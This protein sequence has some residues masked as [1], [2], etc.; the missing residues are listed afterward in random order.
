MSWVKET[1][2]SSIGKKLVMAITGLF[3]IQFLLVHLVGN[4]PL[5]L[6]DNG[7]AF[8]AYAHFMKETK[9][10]V[11]SEVV[12][13][14]GFLFHIVQG[15][16]LV[17]ANKAAREQGYA[18]PHKNK[19]INPLSKYMGPFGVVILVFLIW[20]LMEFFSFKYFRPEA[21]DMIK[22]GEEEIPDLY[23]QVRQEFKGTA[24]LIHI[25]AYGISMIVIGFHLN[26]G[27]QSAFQSIGWKHKR[28]TPIVEKIGAAYSIIVPALF[29]MV[30]VVIYFQS[31]K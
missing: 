31:F 3:L 5:L 15:I 16:Q 23:K 30:P 13:F 4:F 22:Y 11:V 27:F 2:S 17:F 29:V 7:E 24:G 10:I 19:K 9:I 18:V 12:L 1:F 28:Y 8:N 14:A 21:L 6:H 26:H 25:I 20:H